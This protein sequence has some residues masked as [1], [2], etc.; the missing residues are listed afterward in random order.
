MIIKMARVRIAGPRE[1]RDPALRL[2]QDV[3]DLHLIPPEPASAGP[4]RPGRSAAR[5]ASH[6]RRIL[7]D[8]DAV[9]AAA[10]DPHPRGRY[11]AVPP[12]QVGIFDSLVAEL[13][14]VDE[15]FAGAR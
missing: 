14:S 6:A 7:D 10:T 9:L 2:L 13:D 8:V 4:A 12:R 1:Q 11:I 15:R 3:G 5:L